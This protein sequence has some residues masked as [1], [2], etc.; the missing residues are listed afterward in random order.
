MKKLLTLMIC[1]F[2]LTSCDKYLDKDP[3]LRT[4]LGSVEKVSD[5][6][7]SAYTNASYFNMAEARTD[8]V[9]SIKE[10]QEFNAVNSTGYYWT[11]TDEGFQ[12]TPNYFWTNTYKAIAAANHA[13]REIAQAG[14]PELYSAQKGEALMCRA[15]GHFMLVQFFSKFYD[16]A[17]ASTDLGIPYVTEPE[18]TVFKDYERGTVAYVYN[19]IEKD[20]LEGLALIDD[21]VYDKPK[22]HF[23]LKAAHAFAARFYLFKKMYEKVIYHANQVL[24]QVNVSSVM[25]DLKGKYFPMGAQE[26]GATYVSSSENANLLLTEQ[27]SYYAR[28]YGNQHYALSG[29]LRAEIYDNAVVPRPNAYKTWIFNTYVH[30]I[31][32]FNEH[33][34]STSINSANGLAW[35]VAPLFTTEEALFNRAEAF[36]SSNQF[37]LALAD[38]NEFVKNR[39]MTASYNQDFVLDK[40][41]LKAYFYGKAAQEEIS[42]NE[43]KEAIIKACLQFRRMEFMYEGIRWFDI[44]RHKLPVEHVTTEGAVIRLPVNSPKRIIQIPSFAIANGIEPN[45]R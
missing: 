25:R 17:T 21:D 32:K 39:V 38:I 4:D 10:V 26:Y 33:W 5:L 1:S 18:T 13:L 29:A 2:V 44:L 11:D 15:Y 6:L 31:K 43:Y 16:E 24:P 36:A 9:T 30:G 41:R 28:F 12:D 42:D 20:M 45:E 8:N 7:T 34:V 22:F 40:N 3:D 27:T 37:D 35:F 14:K 19:M 23:N